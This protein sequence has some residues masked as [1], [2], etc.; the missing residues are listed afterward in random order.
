M[1]YCY[2]KPLF[3]AAGDQQKTPV[4]IIISNSCFGE[5]E[6][7]VLAITSNPCFG[8]QSLF[9]AINQSQTNL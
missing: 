4:L 8:D 7:F 1:F 3:C 2:Q 6:T 9:C 5:S